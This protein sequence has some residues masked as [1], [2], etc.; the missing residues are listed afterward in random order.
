VRLFV[1]IPLPPDVAGRASVV[2]PTS[3]PAL[4]RIK[5]ENL[6]LTLAFLG[7]TP[8][9]RLP[10]VGTAAEEAARSIAP[11]TLAFDRAGQFP[12]RG[13]PRVVWLAVDAGLADVQRLGENLHRQLRSA[14]L[15]FEDRPLAPH[16]T[17]ARVEEDAS[18]AEARTI[19]AALRSL[20]VPRLVIEVREIVL[21]QST[22]TPQ[23]PRYSR[24]AAVPLG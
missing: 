16:L 15:D 3:L 7:E 11:F 18:G 8:E 24:R 4:R 23:G 1:A 9:G 14:G 20:D 13:R 19:T 6:H 10:D 17:V 5:P 2:L 22:L 21:M 12:E